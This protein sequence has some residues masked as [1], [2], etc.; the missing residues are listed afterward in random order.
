[1][2]SRLQA[3]A[4]DTRGNIA[5]MSALMSAPL[6][7]IIGASVDLGFYTSASSRMQNAADAAVLA[8]FNNPRQRWGKRKARVDALFHQNVGSKAGSGKYKT[9]L[10]GY[11]TRR[12]LVLTYTAKAKRY[13]LFANVGDPGKDRVE[14]KSTAVLDYTKSRFPKL[15][16]NSGQAETS[17]K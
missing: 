14:V 3:F 15:A 17:N 1:M 4:G 6:L 7:L 9:R 2:I 11:R 5:I 13:S 12:K 8:A 16:P 10:H